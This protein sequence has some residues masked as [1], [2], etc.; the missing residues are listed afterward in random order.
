MRMIASDAP[1]SMAWIGS[2]MPTLSATSNEPPV[3][4]WVTAAPLCAK[5]IST[6]RFCGG[7]EALVGR[8]V[9]RPQR[10]L[11]AERAGDDL[12]GGEGRPHQRGGT[13]EADENPA[14]NFHRAPR[15]LQVRSVG[16]RK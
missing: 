15:K 11:A 9:E 16:Q 10:R 14:R 3:S 1:L 2:L 6:S 8:N 12:V 5:L 7:E 13:G 4:C